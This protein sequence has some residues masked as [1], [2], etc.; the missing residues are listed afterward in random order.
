MPRGC[1]QRFESSYSFLICVARP[2]ATA[3]GCWLLV[4]I[5]RSLRPSTSCPR[6][7]LSLSDSPA[8]SLGHQACSLERA[9]ILRNTR[10]AQLVLVPVQI[11]CCNDVVCQQSAARLDMRRLDQLLSLR[12]A[13]WRPNGRTNSV[14]RRLVAR[15]PVSRAPWGTLADC[16][17]TKLNLPLHRCA[18]CFTWQGMFAR[19]NSCHPRRP[20][21]PS[22]RRCRA[23]RRAPW[24]RRARGCRLNRRPG[25]PR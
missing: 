13:S 8:P 16:E 2:S 21:G 18:V 5:A 22:N 17:G 12:P 23:Q 3:H 15:R 11:K 9:R 25:S 24:R 4:R 6:S 7:R 10:S 19:C 20:S 14:A 1:A